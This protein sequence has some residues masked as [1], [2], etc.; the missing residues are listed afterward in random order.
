MPARKSRRR[1][2]RPA[3]GLPDVE[4]WRPKLHPSESL[5]RAFFSRCHQ[6]EQEILGRV[7]YEKRFN[8]QNFDSGWI[9]EE[10]IREAL[11]E[12]L[13]NRYSV[14]T[15]SLSDSKGY[16]AGDCDVVIFNDEWFPAVKA[17]PSKD[18]RK[19][20]LPIEGA[21]AVLEVK[22]SLTR[23]S[24]EDAMR[25]LVTCHRLFRPRVAFDRLVE[26]DTRNA[27]THWVSNPLFSAVVAADLGDGLDRDKAVE[28]FI[29][30]NQ[31]LPRQ[32]VV[33]ALCI[34]G[35]G[36]I[37]WAYRPTSSNPSVQLKDLASATFAMDDRYSELMPVYGNTEPEDSPFYDLAQG[38]MN[39]CF[40]QVLGPENVTVHYGRSSG[41]R[42]PSTEGA[43][44]KPDRI[45]LDSLEDVCIGKHVCTEHAYESHP[46]LSKTSEMGNAR[47][48]G[49][50]QRSQDGAT[51]HVI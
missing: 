49:G 47:L 11:R 30:I 13:P 36:T 10:I 6:I 33:R 40:T 48:L 5:D 16:S 27:C 46:P 18:S 38:L 26:N 17:G 22:Q 1:I 23:K 39:H 44:L 41:G 29:R 14:R 2:Q 43:T 7:A 15:G 3:S 34:L 8:E 45:M 37:S 42:I 31:L 21:Y 20:Y 32:N 19:V 51:H 9:V 28:H 24:L 25:K 4:G 50:I 35:H 12:L